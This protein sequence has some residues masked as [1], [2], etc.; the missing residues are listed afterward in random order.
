MRCCST[1]WAFISCHLICSRDSYKTNK[2][3]LLHF[4][5][6]KLQWWM[7]YFTSYLTVVYGWL[8]AWWCS[9][10]SRIVK[11]QKGLGTNL[12]LSSPELLSVATKRK[13]V[14][15]KHDIIGYQTW[16]DWASNMWR[17]KPVNLLCAQ[18]L[19]CQ[20][21][22]MLKSSFGRNF[23]PGVALPMSLRY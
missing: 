9:S 5:T 8:M 10:S 6:L 2:A 12:C 19:N 17:F 4:I 11:Y 14:M 13:H 23:K 3:S 16:N 7:H 22:N 18:S 1:T 15:Q 21:V 20:E